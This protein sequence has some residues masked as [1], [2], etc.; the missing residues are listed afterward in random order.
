ME[1]YKFNGVFDHVE[2]TLREYFSSDPRYSNTLFVL[3]YNVL[4]DLTAFRRQY[5]GYKI[6]VIQLEQLYKESIWVNRQ[7]YNVLKSADEI[8]D[9]D[10]SNIKWMREN[11]K[12]HAKF[13]PMMYTKA[14]E[15]IP[16]VNDVDMNID[17]LFYGYTNPRR[18]NLFYAMNHKYGGRVKFINLY[19]IW[20][21]ELDTYI[22]RSKIILNVHNDNI[23]KQE[24]VRMYYPV[25]NNRCVVSEVSDL[26]YMGN[27]IIEFKGSDL[28]DGIVYTLNSGK[29][30][31]VALN[32]GANYLKISDN[33]KKRSSLLL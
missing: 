26:N 16:S 20:G 5:V 24:Q 33:F 15:K 17:I 2:I 13:F 25:I 28:I 23:S 10:E 6:I 19:G 32:A 4:H 22:S 1:V 18:A 11:Y 31:D 9:Y 7:S 3:G 27:S 12:L 30:K 21:E 8:W 29:W 14:L